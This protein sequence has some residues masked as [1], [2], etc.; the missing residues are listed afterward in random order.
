MKAS[1]EELLADEVT[2]CKSSN[3][4]QNRCAEPEACNI[5]TLWL[6]SELPKRQTPW[7]A[8][9]NLDWGVLSAA[10]VLVRFKL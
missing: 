6:L 9:G 8:T 10:G 7:R 4:V 2:W 5:A 3:L 1:F